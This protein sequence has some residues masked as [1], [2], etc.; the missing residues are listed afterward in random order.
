MRIKEYLKS[1]FITL[2]Y[3]TAIIGTA[4]LFI[5]M[6]GEILRYIMIGIMIFI[7]LPTLYCFVEWL[8]KENKGDD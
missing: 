5:M 3:I 7:I 2:C 4:V 6:S 1:L 8:L